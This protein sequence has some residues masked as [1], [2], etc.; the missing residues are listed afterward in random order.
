M[1]VE[2]RDPR[3]RNIVAPGANLEVIGSGFLFTEGPLWHP[4]E[5]FLLFSDIPG[6]VIR[7]WDQK[8]G[9][10]PFRQPSAMANGLTYDR[11][12]RLVACHHQTSSVTRTELDGTIVTLATHYDGKELNSPNDIVVKSDGSIYFTDPTYGRKEF[13][14]VARETELRHRGVYRLS[15]DGVLTLLVDDFAQPNGLCFSTD[16]D[17][18]FVNDTEQGHVRVFDVHDDGSLGL[19]RVFAEPVGTGQGAPDGMKLDRDGNLYTT[20]PGGVHVF[21]AEGAILGVIQVPEVC[22]NFTWGG[23][24]L[25]IMFLAASTSL[26][27]IKVEI[28]GKPAF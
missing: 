16:E 21:D 25:D 6:N 19:G 5:H 17:L 1:T 27:T 15:P 26:Y 18:L 13:F 23:Q 22:A 24:D 12:G 7:R 9:V 2:V 20:G 8:D 14:G 28:P 11:Q 10:Q 3:M 4:V